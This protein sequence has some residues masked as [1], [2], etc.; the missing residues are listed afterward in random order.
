MRTKEHTTPLITEGERATLNRGMIPVSFGVIRCGAECQADLCLSECYW[1]N[2]NG[3]LKCLYLE[4]LTAICSY[5][6][7]SG[8]LV[9]KVN[10]H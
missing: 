2:G 4:N 9:N 6:N 10:C 7:W 8:R 3:V 5:P 1:E